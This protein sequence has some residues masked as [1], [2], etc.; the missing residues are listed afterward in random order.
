MDKSA[1]TCVQSATGKIVR[2]LFLPHFACLQEKL[3]AG[4]L[5]IIQTGEDIGLL[6]TF[7]RGFQNRN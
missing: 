7:E 2:V 6:D 5:I 3:P 1:G 4:L